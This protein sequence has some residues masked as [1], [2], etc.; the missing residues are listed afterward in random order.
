M[1]FVGISI[2]K[3]FPISLNE[4]LN[5]CIA[6]QSQRG[7]DGSFHIILSKNFNSSSDLQI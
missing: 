5:Y 4:L 2:S 6:I 7:A 1:N 3:I